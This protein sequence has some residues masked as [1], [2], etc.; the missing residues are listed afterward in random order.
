LEVPV[1]PVPVP[2]P[3][4]VAAVAGVVAITLVVPVEMAVAD[5]FV[6]FVTD[7]VVLVE[8]MEVEV[9]VSAGGVAAAVVDPFIIL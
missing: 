1:V 7:F 3:V 5:S 9:V 6:S 8:A 4:P 2:V